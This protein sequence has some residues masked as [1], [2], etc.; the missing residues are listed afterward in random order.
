MTIEPDLL[1]P[2]PATVADLG[3]LVGRAKRVDADGAV[4]LLGRGE[5]LAAFVCVVEPA[6]A[7]GSGPTV[8][9]LRTLRLAA[10]AEVDVTVPLAAVADRCARIAAE[11]AGGPGPVRFP[12]PPMQ[13]AAPWAGISPPRT[14][15]QPVGLLPVEVLLAAAR[16]GAAEIAAGTP[17]GAGAAAVARLRGLVWGRG[18]EVPGG[19]GQVPAGT[20]FAAELLGFARAGD[21]EL[22]VHRAGRWVRL[23]AARGYLLARSP[24]TL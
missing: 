3:T 19:D 10:P 12:L 5:V 4:R 22:A 14:G 7:G 21:P 11:E 8:L 20:A 1:L 18:L 23:S 15:W 13:V 6:G 17:E 2:D 16:A 24:A 9:G